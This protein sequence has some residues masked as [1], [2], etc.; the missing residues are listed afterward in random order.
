MNQGGEDA[1]GDSAAD[2]G[3]RPDKLQVFAPL[4]TFSPVFLHSHRYVQE[5]ADGDDDDIG[6]DRDDDD[7]AESKMD[8]GGEDKGKGGTSQQVPNHSTL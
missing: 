4:C 3:S 5:E 8:Q 6:A 7:A 2:A 1:V